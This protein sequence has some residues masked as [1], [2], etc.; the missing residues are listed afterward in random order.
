MPLSETSAHEIANVLR[1]HIGTETL[2]QIVNELL[3]TRGD[4]DF[5]DT[6]RDSCTRWGWLIG[7]HQQPDH[8]TDPLMPVR[9]ISR[10]RQKA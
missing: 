2:E 3:E 6:I 5:R 10:S 8:L 7:D 1:K 9:L 4:K